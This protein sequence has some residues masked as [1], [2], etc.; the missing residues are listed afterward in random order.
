M[1]TQIAFAIRIVPFFVVIVTGASNESR[2]PS[3]SSSITT[4]PPP[5]R[6]PKSNPDIVRMQQR[7]AVIT[8]AIEA[9]DKNIK[10]L[11]RMIEDLNDKDRV[12]KSLPRAKDEE[13]RAQIEENKA[14]IIANIKMTN[15]RI[16]FFQEQKRRQIIDLRMLEQRICIMQEKDAAA[17][18]SR[19]MS[20]PATK[21]SAPADMV[22]V[23]PVVS[24]EDRRVTDEPRVSTQ[25]PSDPNISP[26]GIFAAKRIFLY[27]PV[28]A[29]EDHE[30]APRVVEERL[31][32]RKSA[33]P[34]M[35]LLPVPMSSSTTKKP[36]AGKSVPKQSALSFVP[37]PTIYDEG[38]AH[39]GRPTQGMLQT[40]AMGQSSTI[41]DHRE[42]LRLVMNKVNEIR[43]KKTKEI[44]SDASSLQQEPIGATPDT[45]NKAASFVAICE[46]PMPQLDDSIEVMMWQG[47]G[48]DVRTDLETHKTSD[49][50]DL[51]RSVRNVDQSVN[52]GSPTFRETGNVMDAMLLK[53][54]EI[55]Y[56]V[57]LL[58]EIDEIEKLM[59]GEE[60]HNHSSTEGLEYIWW[61]EEPTFEQ[62]ERSY[63]KGVDMLNFLDNSRTNESIKCPEEWENWGNRSMSFNFD[64]SMNTNSMRVDLEPSPARV[65]TPRVVSQRLREQDGSVLS[66]LADPASSTPK[67]IGKL[68]TS[69]FSSPITGRTYGVKSDL[70]M[71]EESNEAS[72]MFEESN[73]LKNRRSIPQDFD[74]MFD[75]PKGNQDHETS[76]ITSGLTQVQGT[77]EI[78][79][80]RDES[81][82]E[83]KSSN[84]SEK[85]A[86]TMSVGSGEGVA[87]SSAV[88]ATTEGESDDLI[89]WTLD[90]LLRIHRTKKM[91]AETQ[92]E[93]SAGSKTIVLD[94]DVHLDERR[95]GIKRASMKLGRG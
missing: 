1:H 94:I 85:V 23:A 53:V 61:D 55:E 22:C 91:D 41:D 48:M 63:Q 70:P 84:A 88:S 25:T 33:P 52:F 75:S 65:C 92:T 54:D 28:K 27:G 34:K 71:I 38:V 77:E 95:R 20:L 76:K 26:S 37:L 29:P 87:S 4:F 93:S 62:L 80:L 6:V 21:V 43:Q 5:T 11:H 74:R 7:A 58:K 83:D 69:M 36:T 8:E 68:F 86:E 14:E 51:N 47:L 24:V 19:R 59:I 67:T 17:E 31:V 35:S 66:T 56:Y 45:D 50:E 72:R 15:R 60:E 81:S 30:P 16:E 32:S 64:T 90:E 18:Q 12:I 73:E 13:K 82:L 57:Q 46:R 3:F 10:G 39:V 89:N 40:A 42:R 78:A 49:T 2:E 44:N 79:Q 9:L